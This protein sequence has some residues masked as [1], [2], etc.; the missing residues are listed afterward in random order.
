MALN[1][2][3]GS[4]TVTLCL[5]GKDEAPTNI[6]AQTVPTNWTKASSCLSRGCGCNNET[7]R[8]YLITLVGLSAACS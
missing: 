8:L 5:G 1:L 2:D 4:S 3:A 7:V 6:A